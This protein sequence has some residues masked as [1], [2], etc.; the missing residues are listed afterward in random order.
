MLAA[1][2]DARWEAKGSLLDRPKGAPVPE[3]LER[4]PVAAHTLSG[5]EREAVSI[6]KEEEEL[7]ERSRVSDGT[8]QTSE[9]KPV[10]T[11]E[12]NKISAGDP[13][14]QARG[15]PSEEWQPQAWDGNIPAAKR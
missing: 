5:E 10:G 3:K 2:A 9:E 15:G 11:A 14:K 13:W 6:D 7:F 12:E 4:G 1:Q 8:R